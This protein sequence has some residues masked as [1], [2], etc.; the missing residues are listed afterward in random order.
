MPRTLEIFRALAD[1]VRLRVVHVL[2][3]AELSV[4]E[5]VRV[6]K[7]PQSTVS[8]HL[9]PL[10]DAG[11]VETRREGTSVY[12]RRGPMLDDERISGFLADRL[13][14][15]PQAA[16]DALSVRRVLDQRRR[17]SR[18]FF[19]KVAGRYESLTQPGGGWQSLAAA[20]AAGFAGQNV[21]DLGS[22]EGALT[23][24]LARHARVTAVDLSPAMLREVKQRARKLGLADRVSTVEG[25]LETLPIKDRTFDT[26]FLS[27]TL[28]HAARPPHAIREAAR[29]LK[30]GGQMILLDLARHDHEWVREKWAD[31]WLGF[32]DEALAGWIRD[33][34]LQLVATD[35]FGGA[36]HDLAVILMVATK[37]N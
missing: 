8:R 7:L 23:L 30:A 5:L 15:L 11:F 35:H 33:A 34:G 31:Q 37:P 36:N 10:R 4:A 22:G 17:R 28:H 20:L 2:L 18:D 1:E 21:A 24:M 6:L 13:R 16:Q 3:A 29:I 12:Y 32:D 25:D 19:D 26:V 9:K 27:Q 14:E